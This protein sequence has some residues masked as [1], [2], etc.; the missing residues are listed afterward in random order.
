MRDFE[1]GDTLF[2][3]PITKL[4]DDY[5][6]VTVPNSGIQF[7]FDRNQFNEGARYVLSLAGNWVMHP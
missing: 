6:E 1:L 7:S 2:G 3:Y 4:S 5:V